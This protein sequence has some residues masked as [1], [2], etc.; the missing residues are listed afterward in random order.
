MDP[1]GNAP[2]HSIGYFDTF[3]VAELRDLFAQRG[4]VLIGLPPAIVL[5]H[6]DRAVDLW[7]ERPS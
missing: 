2:S 5:D 1:I 7:L 4:F 3:G 6:Y